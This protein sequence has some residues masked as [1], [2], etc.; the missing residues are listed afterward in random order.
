MIGP[1]RNGR[2]GDAEMCEDDCECANCEN[3]RALDDDAD[4]YFYDRD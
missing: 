1:P 2:N 4:M 3:E